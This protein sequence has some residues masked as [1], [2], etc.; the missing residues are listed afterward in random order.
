MD[1]IRNFKER[2]KKNPRRVVFPESRDKR[3]LMAVEELAKEKIL[4]PILVGEKEKIYRSS[5]DLK[6]DLSNVEIQ[7]PKKSENLERYALSYMKKREVEKG[8]AEQL[9][10]KNL[11]FGA[12]MVKES[13]ADGIVAGA[14]NPTAIILQ[15]TRTTIGLAP[16]ISILSSFF[17]M[18]IPEFLGEKEKILIYADAAVNIEPDAQQ[19][20]DIAVSSGRSAKQLL[21]IEPKIALLSFSTKGSASHPLIEKVV[22]ATQFAKEK[23]SSLFID[24]EFQGDT[25]LV[26]DVAQKKLKELGEVAGRA[27]VLIFPDLNSG[28]ICYKLTQYLAKA[29]AYGPILQGA[30]KPIS[31]LS[32][33]AS[34][35]DIVDIASIVAVEAI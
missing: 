6:I 18:V 28:N 32:R 21:G 8:I 24:G 16:G 33:G 23:D 5:K 15:V 2:A 30:A 12:M 3:I 9:V 34:K 4:I 35:D 19:L 17:I 20:A 25:A 29:K 7:D 14:A 10:K 11:L 31:D 1:L 13:D 22:Q 27:D 26:P